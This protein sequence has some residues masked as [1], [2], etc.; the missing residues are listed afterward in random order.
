MNEDKDRTVTSKRSTFVLQSNMAENDN[1]MSVERRSVDLE[2]VE[3]PKR[4]TY[5][6]SG[7]NELNDNDI[8]MTDGKSLQDGSVVNDNKLKETPPPGTFVLSVNESDMRRV[9]TTQDGK[10][11]EIADSITQYSNS[12]KFTTGIKN[13]AREVGD[14]DEDVKINEKKRTKLARPGTFL[15]E[16]SFATNG[17]TSKDNEDEMMKAANFY[18][19]TGEVISDVTLKEPSSLEECVK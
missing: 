5:V 15:L 11:I 10:R 16:T 17:N 6:I 3:R 13:V 7:N 12:S 2:K 18:D 4:G 14:T 1:E 8:Q 19:D 9:E